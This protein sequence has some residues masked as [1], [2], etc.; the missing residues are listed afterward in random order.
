LSLIILG[1]R[2]FIRPP[3]SK[4]GNIRKT[5][6]CR[7]ILRFDKNEKPEARELGEKLEPIPEMGK[8]SVAMWSGHS[9][10]LPLTF[11]E[12]ETIL[13]RTTTGKGTTSVVPQKTHSNHPASAAESQV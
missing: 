1:F 6:E 3:Q 7:L 9:C 8:R 12:G 10:P 4:R 2:L 13:S 5:R 11:L